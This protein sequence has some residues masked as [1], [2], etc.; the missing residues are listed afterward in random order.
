[1]DRGNGQPALAFIFH[2]IEGLE[3]LEVIAVNSSGRIDSFALLVRA[4]VALAGV[5]VEAFHLVGAEDQKPHAG[6]CNRRTPDPEHA[7]VAGARSAR[8]R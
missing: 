4:D 5:F 6:G 3:G 8:W 1:M 2:I 7:A